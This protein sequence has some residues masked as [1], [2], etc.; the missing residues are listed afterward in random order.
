LSK[1]RLRGLS[2]LSWH[3]QQTSSSAGGYR[4]AR[5]S[6]QLRCRPIG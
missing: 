3:R 1:S 4:Q 5:P 6:R 2:L